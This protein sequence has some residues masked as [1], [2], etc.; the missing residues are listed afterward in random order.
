MR[1]NNNRLLVQIQISRALL[2]SFK[3]EYGSY[4]REITQLSQA[5]KDE[6]ALASMQAQKRENEFQAR[7]R[8]KSSK[9]RGILVSIRDGF[10]LSNEEKKNWY[11]E[12]NHRRLEKERIK[13]LKLLSTY[14]YQKSYRQIRKE[15]MPGTSLWLCENPKFR[16]WMTENLKT[17]QFTGKCKYTMVPHVLALLKEKTSRIRKIGHKVWLLRQFYSKSLLI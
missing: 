4:E 11:L 1:P 2:V 17:F 3:A 9:D 10:N 12:V 6:A 13:A 14:D 8:S 15:C 16:S 7:E 5:V